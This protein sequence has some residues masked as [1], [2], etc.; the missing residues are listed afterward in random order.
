M[1]IDKSIAQTFAQRLQQLTDGLPHENCS[2][3]LRSS[4][5]ARNKP[6]MAPEGRGPMHPSQPPQSL[7]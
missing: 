1:V 4:H 2:R 6:I 7:Q 3:Q 5:A